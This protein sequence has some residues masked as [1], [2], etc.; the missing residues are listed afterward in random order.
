M[1]LAIKYLRKTRITNEDIATR[2]GSSDS[3]DFMH[4]VSHWTG[5]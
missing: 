1:R 2:L 4:A 3:A 5:S